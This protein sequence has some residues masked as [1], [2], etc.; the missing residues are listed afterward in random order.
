[1]I[2]CVVVPGM[3]VPQ[4]RPRVGRNYGVYY[5]GKAWKDYRER[6]K[7][8]MEVG[9]YKPYEGDVSV[10]LDF[11]VSGTRMRDID[12]LQKSVFDFSNGWLWKDD[13]QIVRVTATRSIV[14][15]GEEATVM[16]VWGKA[17]DES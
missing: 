2:E 13:S 7:E 17:D 8:A 12:N 14:D 5:Q 3:P 16:L 10:W 11:R 4:P 6:W 15:K 9:G 1:M